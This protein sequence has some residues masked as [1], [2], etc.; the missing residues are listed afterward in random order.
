MNKFEEF[1]F[2]VPKAHLVHKW[3][4]YFEVYDRHFQ[5]FVGKNPVILEIG[6]SEGGSLEM[7]NH[8]FGGQCR[9]YGLDVDPRCKLVE[10]DFK[11]VEIIVGSQDDPTTLAEIRR[12]VPPIDILVDDG[13]HINRHLITTFKALY[14][15]VK[16]G[17]VYLVEDLHTCYWP[18]YGGGL[19][20]PGS[21]I[22]YSKGIIDE[23]N[24]FHIRGVP[25]SPL[26]KTLHS[27]HYYDSI[28]V[29]EKCLEYVHPR[30]TRRGPGV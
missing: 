27:L 16:P 13:S 29:V 19:R 11:N 21:F 25:Q 28:L 3:H 18:E 9:I 17:G 12:R 15:H 14:D 4:H 22:E 1:F 23:L 26:S 20:Q 7:W 10:A 2:K 6:V 24:A 30:A 5:R 8:Y